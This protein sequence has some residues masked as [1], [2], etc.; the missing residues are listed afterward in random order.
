MG[1]L[2]QKVIIITGATGGVGTAA[3]ALF[4]SEG[5]RLVLTGRDEAR[6]REAASACDPERTRCIVSDNTD[7]DSIAAVV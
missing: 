3:A 2:D 5:A 6:L 4:S 1:K 7:A